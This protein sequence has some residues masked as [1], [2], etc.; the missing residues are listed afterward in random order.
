MIA[1]I[2]KDKHKLV[3]DINS[4]NLLVCTANVVCFLSVTY[5]QVH[6]RLGLIME[7]ITMN[8][9]RLL[10]RSILFAI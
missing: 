6:I 7:A 1:H 4:L 9:I 8:L 5:T 10:P 2:F 3:A